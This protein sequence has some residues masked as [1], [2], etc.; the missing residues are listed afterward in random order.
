MFI[1]VYLCMHL[2]ICVCVCVYV[3][4]LVAQSCCLFVTSWTVAHQ[5]PLSLEFSRQEYWSGLLFLSPGDLPEPGI[6]PGSPALQA[7]SLLSEPP[8]KPCIC[9]NVLVIVYR[10]GTNAPVYLC[11]FFCVYVCL[12]MYVGLCVYECICYTCIYKSSHVWIH[13]DML[14]H[15]S[16]SLYTCICVLMCICMCP[17]RQILASSMKELSALSKKKG[18][19]KTVRPPSLE[20]IK[21]RRERF[22]DGSGMVNCV[23]TWKVT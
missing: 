18:Y 17:V 12:N 14:A 5:I 16:V 13:V 7:D 4:V 15:I 11:T 20:E 6:E 9:P 19:V 3:C 1:S 10:C 22:R 2:H 23:R 8:R 21:K